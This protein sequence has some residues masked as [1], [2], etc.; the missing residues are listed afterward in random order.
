MEII[1]YSSSK[2]FDINVKGKGQI[3]GKLKEKE[4]KKKESSNLNS[5]EKQKTKEL[6]QIWRSKILLVSV[7]DQT[8]NQS[9]TGWDS[10]WDF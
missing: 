3:G 9:Q 2:I 7:L 8:P 4:E 1:K 5:E 6:F 10:I